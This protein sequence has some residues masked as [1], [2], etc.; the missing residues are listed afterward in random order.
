MFWPDLGIDADSR[1]RCSALDLAIS[2]SPGSVAACSTMIKLYEHPLSPYAQKCKIAL[3]EKGVEF[4]AV[5]PDLLS[6]RT[7]SA[8]FSS[9]NPRLEVPTLVDGETSIFDSTIILEYI[10]ERWPSPPLLPRSPAERARMR[11][12]E[13]VVDTQY[14][15]VNWGL[16]EMLIFKRADGDLATKIVARAAEQT[17]GL[18]AWLERHLGTAKWLGGDAFGWGDLSVVPY[19]NASV[20]FGQAP[21]QGSKLGEWHA[22]VNERPSVAKT[23]AAANEAA[24]TGVAAIAGLVESGTFKREYRDHRL[25]WMIRSGGMSIVEQGLARGTIRFS[26]EIR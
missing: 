2:I 21:K 9:V 6:G 3:Y 16:M 1:R 7:P 11:M 12:I 8:E 23:T 4:E 13:E 22:R 5:L 17:A 26:Y 20:L 14:D 25:E 18:Q 24:A 10:E 19:V 15:A